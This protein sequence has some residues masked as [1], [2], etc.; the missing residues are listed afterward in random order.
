MH[1]P[2][3]KKQQAQRESRQPLERGAVFLYCETLTGFKKLSCLLFFY[4]VWGLSSRKPW[5][6]TV[7][8]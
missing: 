1:R 5:P 2:E 3:K 6:R 4:P 8:T 7:T